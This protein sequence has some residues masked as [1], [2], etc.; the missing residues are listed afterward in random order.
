[1][2]LETQKLHLSASNYVFSSPRQEMV[3]L[4][5]FI[6]MLRTILPGRNRQQ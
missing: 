1:M 4:T 2:L 5:D 6:H 3:S